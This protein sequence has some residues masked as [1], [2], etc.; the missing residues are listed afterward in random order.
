M[1]VRLLELHPLSVRIAEMARNKMA[2]QASRFMESS[3]DGAGILQDSGLGGVGRCK[4]VGQRL[5]SCAMEAKAFNRRDRRVTAAEI[6]KKRSRRK[7]REEELA[8]KGN[9]WEVVPL[10]T[11]ECDPGH[12]VLGDSPS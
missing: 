12:M 4:G 6:A 8:K 1:V 5:K 9:A 11:C 7:E 2:A 10:R 3:R